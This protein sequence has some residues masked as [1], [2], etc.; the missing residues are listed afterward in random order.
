VRCSTDNLVLCQECDWDAH[1]ICSVSA[2]HDRNQIEGFSGLWMSLGL[3]GGSDL[4]G[5]VVENEG[6]MGW[7]CS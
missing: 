5:E 2:S 6:R 3:R 4:R 1:G 7:E